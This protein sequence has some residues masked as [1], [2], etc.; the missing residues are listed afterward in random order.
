MRFTSYSASC[1]ARAVRAR[2]H[3][4]YVDT[5]S[6]YQNVR[7]FKAGCADEEGCVCVREFGDAA[8]RCGIYT[9]VPWLKM[10]WYSEKRTRSSSPRGQ[11]RV[12]SIRAISVIGI[13]MNDRR[14]CWLC[15]V[16]LLFILQ[17]ASV[18]V[19]KL[20]LRSRKSVQMRGPSKEKGERPADGCLVENEPKEG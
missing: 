19:R 18:G 15:S 14:G 1:A 2:L 17:T 7:V 4:S 5:T 20:A 11:N 9:I 13:F 8:F 12:Q 3:N 6:L 10:K 16:T